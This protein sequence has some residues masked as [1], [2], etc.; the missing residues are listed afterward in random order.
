[1]LYCE[2]YLEGFHIPFVHASLAPTLEYG[3]YSTETFALGSLQLGVAASEGPAFEPPADHPDGGRRIAAYYFWLFPNLMFNFYPWGLS[4]NV[5]KPQGPD[6]AKVSFIN[7]V[8]DRARLDRGYSIDRVEREDEAVVESVQAGLG[9]RFYDR[10][11][12]SPKREAGVHHFHRLLVGALKMN[13]EW[14]MK[15]GE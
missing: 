9:S 8:W 11:R 4:V 13:G 6:R 3:A 10:G 7:Y 2:N 5:V 12:Y 14:R 1:M 15:N